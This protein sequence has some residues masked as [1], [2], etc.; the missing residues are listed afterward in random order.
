MRNMPMWK[1][2][3]TGLLLFLILFILTGVIYPLGITLI[4]QAFFPIQAGGSLV[5]DSD[6]TIRGSQLIGQEF[7]GKG[8]FI[9]RPSA[10]EGSPYN[11]SASGGSNLGPTNPALFSDVDNRIAYLKAR[12]ISAPY[13]SDMVLSSASGL[14][15]HITLD[16]ALS[17][18][19]A[20]ANNRNVSENDLRTIVM[21]HAEQG[22][23]LFNEGPFVNVL[24]LNR[25][26]DLRFPMMKGGN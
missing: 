16:A 18:V 7:A 23:P 25:D 15:P 11:A 6:G 20:I 24:L 2:V 10:T 14:D 13:S 19:S 12:E 9:G 26:L 21:S 22:I 8:Y 5:T 3:K 1:E 4:G 17:Q